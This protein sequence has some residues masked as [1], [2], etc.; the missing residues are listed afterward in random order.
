MA[1][2][3]GTRRP[4]ERAGG[5][6]GPS[7]AGPCCSAGAKPRAGPG[8]RAASGRPPG[9]A[10]RRGVRD[11]AHAQRLDDLGHLLALPEQHVGLAELGDDLLCPETLA[12]HAPLPCRTWSE[13]NLGLDRSGGGGPPP[14]R[15]FGRG[16]GRRRRR[17]A[18]AD[19]RTLQSA[20]GRC[21]RAGPGRPAAPSLVRAPC[22]GTLS[23]PGAGQRMRL[24]VPAGR[25]SGQVDAAP[26]DVTI[27]GRAS[28]GRPA[29]C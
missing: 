3:P 27:F 14:G 26:P 17:H 11:L 20:T 8:P 9:R 2:R 22:C 7:A 23:P 6:R 10:A 15:P 16:T 18:A 19:D 12:R 5:S 24:P 1:A 29:R 13:P 4:R 25:S 28:D 21:R